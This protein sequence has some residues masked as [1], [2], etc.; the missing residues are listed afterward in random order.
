[1]MIP[2]FAKIGSF[3]EE[4]IEKM[5]LTVV[6]LACAWL[7]ITRVILSPN[8]VV[9][10]GKSLSPAAIDEQIYKAAEAL[11]QKLNEPP[12]QTEAYKPKVNEYLALL[13]SSIKDI[14]TR[15]WPVAPFV[16]GAQ[17]SVA[18]YNLPRIPDVNEVAVEHI[19][20]VAYVPLGEVTPEKPYDKAGNE[21][22]DLDLVTVSAK[23]DIA[24]LFENCN[25]SFVGDVDPE[26]ADPCLAKPIFA[27]VQL[28]RQQ[29]N[30]DGA[31]SDW[32]NVP[33]TRID[34]YKRL[35]AIVEDIKDLPPGGLKVQMLQMDYKPVQIGLLQPEAY[36][37]ASAD[38]EWFPPELHR[39][40][41]DFQKRTQMEERREA[42]EAEKKEERTRDNTAANT[43][44]R[45]QTATGRRG[46]TDA[47][48]G[49][50]G[51]GGDSMYGGATDARSRRGRDRTGGTTGIPGDTGRGPGR[52]SGTGT[53]GR[54]PA[55][56]LEPYD[57][58]PDGLGTGTTGR[59]TVR[60]PS[61][62][63]VY[64]KYDAV[65]L[66]RLTEFEK[67]REPLLF[68][69]HDDTVEPG[70]TY[71]YRIRLG[72]FNPVAGMNRLS[73]RDKARTN[74]VILWSNYSGITD[75]VEI[76]G[77]LY[78]FANNVRE[79]DKA[80]TVQVSR[81]ALGRWYSHDFVVRQGELIGEALE[82]EPEKP[83]RTSLR[84]GSLG[85]PIGSLAGSPL[86]G[87]MG[88]PGGPMGPYAGLPRPEEKTNVPEMI[89]YATGAVMVDAVAVNDWSGQPT[90]RTRHYYDMLYSFD[91]IAIEHM[92]AGAT[93]WEPHVQAVFSRIG[94][95]Q[96]E[97][98]EPF[99]AFGT[100]G[101]RQR[102]GGEYDQTGEY[103]EYMMEEM[104]MD[105][106]MGTGG[107]PLY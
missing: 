20:A 76:M 16:P 73:E 55:D 88:T 44:R 24:S 77:R 95:L 41:V 31:W 106:M 51:A 91:G 61:V 32:Q 101:R 43:S 27:A 15:L 45:P 93:Y 81:L 85:S 84:G 68:W 65:R 80:V 57:L 6:G 94:R 38:E 60:R 52:R 92:P 36:Q 30:G 35:F 14:D 62:N 47:Y 5:I 4:H 39:E 37:I 33:R 82:P 99:K 18:V 54:T 11:R 103:D 59:R 86:G 22:N 42:K 89:D 34:P 28:Q 21:P 70:K 97:P 25:E 2:N 72:V 9:F 71:R 87:P 50:Y 46:G 7:L 8:E 66:T 56:T 49:G 74:E 29:L 3:F 63:D 10:E 75:P 90:L 102:M 64:F 79:T 48:G 100:T 26:W 98:H 17:T 1:M 83:E 23:F 58:G 104:Y 19:G 13:D 12:E 107:R 96:R 40:F 105:D 69:A 67:L 78:F 53:R